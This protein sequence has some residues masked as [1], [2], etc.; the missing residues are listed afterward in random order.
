M[1]QKTWWLAINR[2]ADLTSYEELKELRLIALLYPEVSDLTPLLTVDRKN[3]AAWENHLLARQRQIDGDAVRE[4]AVRYAARAL[5]FLLRFQEDDL[6]VAVEGTHVRG[7]C[8]MPIDAVEGYRY[9]EV[10]N[11]A[12]I[13]ADDV[14]WFDLPPQDAQRFSVLYRGIQG[15]RGMDKSADLA[16]LVASGNAARRGE[17]P[18]PR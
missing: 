10:F 3:K 7:I 1:A 8:Q 4:D 9:D 17:Q 6:V 14:A 15:A 18:L 11:G 13:V 12:H 16:C 5:R 2:N